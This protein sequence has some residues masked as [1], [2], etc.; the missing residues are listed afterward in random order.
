MS[1]I[2]EALKKSE[3]E[4]QIG[5]VPDISVVQE[6]SARPASQWPRWL[7]AAVLINVL[8]LGLIAWQPWKARDVAEQAAAPAAETSQPIDTEPASE[9]RLAEAGPATDDLT[10]SAAPLPEP[11]TQMPLP[12]PARA[13]APAARP[14]EE[15]FEPS[16]P[17]VPRW[18][19]LP[20]AVRDG[21]PVPRID[22]HVFAREPARRF[23]LINL[24]KHK[25]GDVLDE[26][27]TVEAILADGILLSYRG[28]R[29]R[30]GRP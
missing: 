23:V 10:A 28:Q 3:Q 14:A 15:A 26:G 30:V 4:R 25:E 20:V 1:Y 19:D 5:H 12:S 11:V 13:P 18:D 8:I 7:A 21:L 22:V 9:P 16:S 2:L 24:R 6:P 17:E 29:Y 27:A